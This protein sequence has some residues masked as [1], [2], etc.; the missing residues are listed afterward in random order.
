MSHEMR[1]TPHALIAM[2]FYI[3]INVEYVAVIKIME[4]NREKAEAFY[5]RQQCSLSLLRAF[6]A[7]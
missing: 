3:N 1:L 7:D 2:E 6:G 5:W 4:K